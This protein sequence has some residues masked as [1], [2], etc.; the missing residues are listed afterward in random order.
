MSKARF[1]EGPRA[2]LFLL[3]AVFAC[4]AAAAEDVAREDLARC[5]AMSTDARKLACF[6]ALMAEDARSSGAEPAAEPAA[7]P[8]E[9]RV[10]EAPDEPPPAPVPAAAAPAASAPA[11]EAIATDADAGVAAEEFGSEYLRDEDAE[12]ED[13]KLTATVNEVK[14]DR[15]NRLIFHFANGQVWRQLEPRRF[16]Y[17]RRE[18]FDVVISRGMLGDYQLRVG[19]EGRM[20]RIKR[21]Q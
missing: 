1:L 12:K 4:G 21:L 11:P 2:P 6:E 9:M 13:E 3:A 14:T 20:T 15:T 8:V 18:A 17:P 5:A 10:Q 16:Q 19:G 7:A